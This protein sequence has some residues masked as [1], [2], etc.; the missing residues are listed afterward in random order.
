MEGDGPFC[1]PN[2]DCDGPFS[3]PNLDGD[4]PYVFT[5]ADCVVG[6]EREDGGGGGSK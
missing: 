3:D 6:R 5:D 1:V 4:G 2:L